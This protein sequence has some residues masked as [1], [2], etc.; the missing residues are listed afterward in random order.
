M[1]SLQ[2]SSVQHDDTLHSLE[3]NLSAMNL[4]HLRAESKAFGTPK[5]ITLDSGWNP[6]AQPQPSEI[7]SVSP[8]VAA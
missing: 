2:T 6:V 1:V 5:L 8:D 7:K 4:R 3:T